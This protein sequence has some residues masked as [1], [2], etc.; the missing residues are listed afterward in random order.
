MKKRLNRKAL[1]IRASTFD[2]ERNPIDRFWLW[3]DRLARGG[4]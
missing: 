2:Y 3:L 1:M 4:K